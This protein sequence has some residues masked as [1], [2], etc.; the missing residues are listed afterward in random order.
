MKSKLYSICTLCRAYFI[1]KKIII[2][3]AQIFNFV[4]TDSITGLLL[5]SRIYL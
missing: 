2:S 3:I 1:K 4:R 5:D